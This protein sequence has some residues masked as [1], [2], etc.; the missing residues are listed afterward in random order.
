METL[1]L[2]VPRGTKRIGWGDNDNDNDNNNDDNDNKL[3]F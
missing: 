3:T 2:Y 1:Q